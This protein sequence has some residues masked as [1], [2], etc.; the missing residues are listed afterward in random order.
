MKV[1]K[2]M[3]VILVLAIVAI[4]LLGRRTSGFGN[5]RYQPNIPSPPPR[6]APPPPPPPLPYSTPC[7]Q[8][9]LPVGDGK[10]CYL[11]R[12]KLPPIYSQNR[13]LCSD[14]TGPRIVPS[15]D[16]EFNVTPPPMGSTCPPGTVPKG[17]GNCYYCN[18]KQLPFNAT[19]RWYCSGAGDALVAPPS[20]FYTQKI[21]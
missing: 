18:D 8:G 2:K 3:M 9:V 16:R 12:D 7:P 11:C 4:I 1:D 20:Y 14:S 5:G 17:D 21:P 13:L 19:G 10:N 15:T 6:P